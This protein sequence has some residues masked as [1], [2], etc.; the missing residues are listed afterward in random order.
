MQTFNEKE[1]GRILQEIMGSSL[2]GIVA[3]FQ[4]SDL[5]L[6][7]RKYARLNDEFH[8]HLVEAAIYATLNERAILVGAFLEH[9]RCLLV[10]IVCKDSIPRELPEHSGLSEFVTLGTLFA[11]LESAAV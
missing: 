2:S 8:I 4:D 11:D 9:F 5:L 6:S 10:E 3:A 7:A 1:K